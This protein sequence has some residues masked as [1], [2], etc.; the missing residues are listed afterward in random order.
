MTTV[1][2]MGPFYQNTGTIPIVYGEPGVSSLNPWGFA[3]S[4]VD[5]PVNT[6]VEETVPSPPSGGIA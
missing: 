5:S 4:G 6:N 1:N 3:V 2:N